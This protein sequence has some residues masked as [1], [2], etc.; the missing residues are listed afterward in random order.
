MAVERLKEFEDNEKEAD[1]YKGSKDDWNRKGSKDDWNR[2]G[3]K[4][5]WNRRGSKGDWKKGLKSTSEDHWPNEGRI[6]YVE[7]SMRYR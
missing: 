5:D 1:W 6:E 4:D 2:K 7:Y 3:S